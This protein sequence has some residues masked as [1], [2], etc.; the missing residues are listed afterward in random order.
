LV[1]SI[2]YSFFDND[3]SKESILKY[4]KGI[5]TFKIN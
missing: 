3:N 2:T 4:M 1:C 5:L